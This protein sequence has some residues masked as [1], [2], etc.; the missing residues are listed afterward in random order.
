MEMKTI[1]IIINL[2]ANLNTEANK[3]LPEDKHKKRDEE[4]P[5]KYLTHLNKNVSPETMIERLYSNREIAQSLNQEMETNLE[6]RFENLPSD[7]VET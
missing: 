6:K 2:F 1:S 4:D 3:G 5:P 7:M